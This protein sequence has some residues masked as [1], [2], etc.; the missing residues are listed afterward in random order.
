MH[1]KCLYKNFKY[2][3][4]N[5]S[6]TIY[7][8]EFMFQKE[9]K[10]RAHFDILQ[11][12]HH[13]NPLNIWYEIRNETAINMNQK[14]VIFFEMLST[15]W[16]IF[17]SL[18]FVGRLQWNE[19]VYKVPKISWKITFGSNNTFKSTCVLFPTQ[20]FEKLKS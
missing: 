11:S 20:N 9:K 19:H 4:E 12:V 14:N 7:V 2:T 15:T 13:F 10:N 18:R 3:H 17:F 5:S 1:S 8:H 16:I 6:K